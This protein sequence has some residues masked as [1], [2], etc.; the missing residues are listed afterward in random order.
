MGLTLSAQGLGDTVIAATATAVLVSRLL[1]H[2]AAEAVRLK[3]VGRAPDSSWGR[4]EP[5]KMKGSHLRETEV[6]GWQVTESLPLV[7][8]PDM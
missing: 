3:A 1:L 6:L 7:M 8:N 4:Q 2:S 5:S